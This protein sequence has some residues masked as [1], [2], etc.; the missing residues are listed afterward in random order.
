MKLMNDSF[1]QIPTRVL[2]PE[3]SEENSFGFDQIL[4]ELRHIV[5]QL[6]MGNLSLEKALQMFE[7]GVRLSRHGAEILS[8][9]EHR[10]ERLVQS[11]P[12]IG[13]PKGL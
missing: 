12:E 6:E 3:T 1:S 5:S 9:A 2:V 4:L 10:I 11:E 8:A 13:E 7:E